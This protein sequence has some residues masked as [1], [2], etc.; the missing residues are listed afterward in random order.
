MAATPA[1]SVISDI[2]ATTTYHRSTRKTHSST[3]P[4]SEQ[5]GHGA[6]GGDQEPALQVKLQQDRDRP[7]DQD[8]QRGQR[9]LSVRELDVGPCS[10][11][12][13]SS[14]SS[15]PARRNSR[16]IRHAVRLVAI[17][18]DPDEGAP[19]GLGGQPAVEQPLDGLGRG[20]VQRGGRLVQQ[21]HGRVELEGAEQPDDLRF[22]ARE[23]AA[24][25]LQERAIAAQASQQVDDAFRIEPPF[26]VG[27][28]R[29]RQP[30]VVFHA[31]L[32]Q[33]G[34]LVQVDHLPAVRR[35]R[36]ACDELALPAD[37]AGVERVEHGHGPEQHGLPRAE[38][39]STPS[40]SPRLR[41]KLTSRISQPS[42]F[43]LRRP[44]PA[45]SIAGII[46]SPGFPDG[47][48][49]IAST[50]AIS[51]ARTHDPHSSATPDIQAATAAS[52][53]G[54]TRIG[55]SRQ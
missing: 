16:R 30:Q 49:G 33:G 10:C 31:P 27:L 8:Q 53:A 22:A 17:V 32:E 6:S 52:S 9:D 48:W 25:L 54:T 50:S 46:P 19:G 5:L 45:A 1:T 7:V 4:I 26:A 37:R 13:L 47:R 35:H 40:R 21:E 23:V 44:M 15:R 42:A 24:R 18:A 20:R 43:G 14:G 29:E 12:S 51:S 55:W 34:P 2:M 3:S 39:P 38:G 41:V 28:E 36:L 11:Q